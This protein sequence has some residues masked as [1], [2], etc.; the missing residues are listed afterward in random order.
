MD[1]LAAPNLM[2]FYGP[3]GVLPHTIARS[4]GTWGVLNLWHGSAAVVVLFVVTLVAAIALTI[5]FCSRLAAVLVLIGIISF[6]QRNLWVTN[7][8]DGL[9]RNLAFFCA[10]AP[11][12][13][14]LS[15][16]RLLRKPDNFWEFPARAPW[17]LR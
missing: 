4:P 12:G 10:L 2:A 3:N 6:E 1:G 7:S 14:S 13:E 5:G 9:V 11:S 8:G 15:V 17:A 16:D